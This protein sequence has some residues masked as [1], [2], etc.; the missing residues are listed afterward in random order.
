MTRKMILPCFTM[1]AVLLCRPVQATLPPPIPPEYG[2]YGPLTVCEDDLSI[3]LRTNEAVHLVGP[4][5]R[6]I[7][8]EY[9]IAATPMVLPP[10]AFMLFDGPVKHGVF[11]VGQFTLGQT[12]TSAAIAFRY[13]GELPQSA[14]SYA[15]FAPEGFGKDDVRYAI[16]TRAASSPSD[17]MVSML[18]VASPSFDGSDADKALLERFQLNAAGVS[19]CVRPADLAA[20]KR[21]YGTAGFARSFDDPFYAGRYP[22]RPDEGAG[23]HCQGGIGFAFHAGEQLRRPWKSLRSGQSYWLRDGVAVTLSGPVEPMRRTDPDNASEHPAGQLHDSAITFYPSR[24]VGPPYAPPGVREDGSWLIELGKERNSRLDIR[25]PA[26]ESGRVGFDLIERLEF[27]S[28]DD[29]RCGAPT[30]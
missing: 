29:P 5:F 4:I 15:K 19:D 7:N 1:L 24:G 14:I 21:D 28:P 2:A 27:V 17:G 22:P 11:T 23:Y 12:P 20:G 30:Q 26:G 3:A 6:V 9:L 13:S 18:I 8:D 10:S 25:F 16:E